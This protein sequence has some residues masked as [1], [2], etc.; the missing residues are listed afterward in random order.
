MS[1]ETITNPVTES[2]NARFEADI[3]QI[4]ALYADFCAA[5]GLSID[6]S[7]LHERSYHPVTDRWHIESFRKSGDI[8]G[9]LQFGNEMLANMR[10][11]LMERFLVTESTGRMFIRDEQI[12]S[13]DLPTEPFAT[14]ISRGYEYRRAN[15]LKERDPEKRAAA[16][17]DFDREG[18]LGELAGFAYIEHAM[19]TCDIGTTVMSFSPPS[20]AEGS[21]YKYRF[22]DFFTV[23]KEN[24]ER[25]VERSRVAVNWTNSDYANHAREIKPDFFNG[26]DNRSMDAWFLSHPQ[27][28][29]PDMEAKVSGFKDNGMDIS[30]FNALF[31]DPML[32]RLLEH[33][34]SEISAQSVN[35]E[36]VAL[37]FN[38]ILNHADELKRILIAGRMG[39]GRRY[40]VD[41]QIDDSSFRAYVDLVGRQAV[42]TVAGGGCP[43]NKGL[44]LGGKGFLGNSVF[45]LNSVSQFGLGLDGEEHGFNCPDCGGWI[46]WGD[47]DVCKHCGLEKNEYGRRENKDVC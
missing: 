40:G 44:N 41:Y 30:D 17:K 38:A 37:A 11:N 35:W 4:H 29:T 25:Y 42:A 33:Y 24:G 39:Q 28:V 23:R 2:T 8:Q 5:L 27:I 16:E 9:L 26:F 6:F 36:N 7:D 10:T 19:L 20:Q 45:S 3:A 47:G 1:V 18:E 46:A 31:N 21:P 14:V 34:V 32:E 13:E 12:Y 15:A 22:V 43:P